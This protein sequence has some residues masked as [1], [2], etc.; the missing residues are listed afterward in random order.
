MLKMVA[1]NSQRVLIATQN[2]GKVREIRRLL[3]KISIEF[4]GLDQVGPVTAPEEDGTTFLEN[5][6]IKARY[7][8]DRFGNI[9][10][11]DDSGLVVDALDGSPGVHSARYGGDGLTDAE[12]TDLLL[13]ELREVP[14]GKRTARFVC[15]VVVYDPSK[16]G[17]LLHASGTVE[18]S[19]TREPRGTDGFGYDPVFVPIGETRTTA[20]M[21]AEE[22]DELSHRGRAIRAIEPVLQ[23]H[24]RC[25]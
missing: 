21:S 5:A 9:A 16:D 10:L 6:V 25:V 20:E 24:L 11:A 22:K 19:I 17:K 12:R 18:G 13:R 23:T 1:S 4:V 3:V 15:A 2:T 7:Y 14:A 8:A